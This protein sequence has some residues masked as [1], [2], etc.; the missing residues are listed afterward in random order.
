MNPSQNAG[1]LVNPSVAQFMREGRKLYVGV[2][3]VYS[4]F[5]KSVFVIGIAMIVIGFL[6]LFATNIGGY[7]AGWWLFIGLM[8]GLA[9]GWS[10]YLFDFVDFDLKERHFK[11]RCGAWPNRKTYTGSI[12]EVDAIVLTYEKIH[13]GGMGP[14][15]FYLRLH[16][17]DQSIAP[18]LLMEIM[19][20]GN[21]VIRAHE[22]VQGYAPFSYIRGLESGQRFSTA[23]QTRFFNSTGLPLPPLAGSPGAPYTQPTQGMHP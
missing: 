21:A 3:L 17:K 13:M 11:R 7:G 15:A 5:A 1:K 14:E 23:L 18:T 6:C 2:P 9:A 22:I 12:N 4:Y 10:I 8:V 20:E 16:W 19:L